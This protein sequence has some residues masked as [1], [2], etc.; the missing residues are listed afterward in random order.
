M[1]KFRISCLNVVAKKKKNT[2]V[3]IYFLFSLLRS[4]D[5]TYVIPTETLMLVTEL[6]DWL[7]MCGGINHTFHNLENTRTYCGNHS[8]LL[9]PA[10]HTTYIVCVNFIYEWLVL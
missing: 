9:L 8:V 2:Y 4:I 5:I 1:G 10:S 3:G 6:N 7:S